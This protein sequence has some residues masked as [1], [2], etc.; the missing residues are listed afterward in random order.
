MFLIETIRNLFSSLTWEKIIQFILDPQFTGWLLLLKII[1]L[2]FSL[3]F[4]GFIIFALIKTSW[5]KYLIIR[6]LQEFL[7]YRPFSLR[8]IEKEWQKIKG[9]LEI[10]HESEWKLAIIEADEI[11]DDILNQM[12]FGGTSL[13]ERLTSLTAVSLPN[14]EEVKEAHQI[15]NNI[16][17][18]PSYRLTLVETKRIIAIYEKA[19]TDLQAL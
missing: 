15:R 11:M 18:D 8:R 2:V 19:L 10:E 3:F 6:D 1:F 9:R 17:H 5:L 13:G 7:T 16:I 14:I 12:G 4:I